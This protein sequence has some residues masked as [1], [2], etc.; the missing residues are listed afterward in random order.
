MFL[1]LLC[2]IGFLPSKMRRHEHHLMVLN[3][4]MTN[5]NP[6]EPCEKLSRDSRHKRDWL[7]STDSAFGQLIEIV[8]WM[9]W[10]NDG[11]ID[12]EKDY[13]GTEHYH[14]YRIYENVYFRAAD[15]RT[16]KAERVLMHDV[17]YHQPV[18]S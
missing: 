1:L 12:A 2:E 6:H 11:P 4:P 13:D 7:D 5:P 9:Q 14:I 15:I 18:A 16:F 3:S 10:L 17:S 8:V